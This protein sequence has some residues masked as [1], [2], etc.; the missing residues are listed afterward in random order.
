MGENF[1]GFENTVRD[2]GRRG[3][4]WVALRERRG[5]V[6][7]WRQG[8]RRGSSRGRG[9]STDGGVSTVGWE[10]IAFRI[11]QYQGPNRRR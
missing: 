9:V 4:R 11:N 3:D 7:G 5:A 2:L 10:L 1:G 8:C 6:S